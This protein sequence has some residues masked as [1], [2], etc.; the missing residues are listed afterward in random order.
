M[1]N[2]KENIPSIVFFGTPEFARFCLEYLID[3]SFKIKGVVTAPDRKAGRG[4]KVKSSSVK[5]YSE[6]LGLKIFQPLNLSDSF[7]IS[8]LQDLC[9]DIYVVVAFRMLPKKVWSIPPLGTI[10]LHASLLPNYR[11]AAPINWVLINGESS[12]GVT[13]FLINENIDT[14]DILMQ[15][16]INIKDDFCAGDIHGKL[17]DIGTPLIVKTLIDLKKGTLIPKK[18]GR[19]KKFSEAPKLTPENTKINWNLTLFQINNLIRGLS[20]YPGAWTEFSNNNISIRIKIFKAKTII[21]THNFKI[22]TVI[23]EDSNI[24]IAHREGLLNCIEIQLPNKKRMT[25]KALLNGYIF[26]ENTNV[27]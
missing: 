22:N 7:F 9:A 24:F 3:K 2:N 12:T 27:L 11:G 4:K 21:K 23:I 17:L 8:K 13:T 26:P 19:F 10:N 16:K 6:K 1:F 18:Q 14:G 5:I 20:P 15:D 25:T